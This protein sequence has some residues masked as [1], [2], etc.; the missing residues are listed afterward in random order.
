MLQPRKSIQ[1]VQGNEGTLTAPFAL[2]LGP[3]GVRARPGTPTDAKSTFFSPNG[4]PWHHFGQP[5]RGS[6]CFFGP[7]LA[8]GGPAPSISTFFGDMFDPKTNCLA[9]KN[10]RRPR[11]RVTRAW[12]PMGPHGGRWGPMGAPWGPHGAPWGPMGPHGALWGPLG[13]LG[14]LGALGPGSAAWA[15]PLLFAAPRKG[16]QSVLDHPNYSSHF[17]L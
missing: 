1:E 5:D 16:E 2:G 10:R 12:G 14:A 6:A 8:R 11:R 4:S 13:P 3:K 15:K 9:R 7:D 17:S